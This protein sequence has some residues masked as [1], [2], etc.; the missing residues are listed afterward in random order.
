M[1]RRASNGSNLA[2]ILIL[3]FLI[4]AVFIFGVSLLTQ[5]KDPFGKLPDLPITEASMNGNSLRGNYYKVSGKVEERWV[6]NQ[7]EGVHLSVEDNGAT[8]PI[9]IQIPSGLKRPNLERERSYSFAV[10]VGS[11]GIIQATGIKRL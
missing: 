5:K 8:K 9:F 6:K 2:S 3:G 4:I 11:G 1:S 7:Y 10:E